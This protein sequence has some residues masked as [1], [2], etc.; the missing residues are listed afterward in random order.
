MWNM[1]EDSDSAYE[2]AVF[3]LTCLTYTCVPLILSTTS[4]QNYY[5]PVHKYLK[6]DI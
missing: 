6:L 5:V 3:Y 2:G 4:S 1:I